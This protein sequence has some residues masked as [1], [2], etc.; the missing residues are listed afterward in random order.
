MLL[1][2][3][4]LLLESLIKWKGI[5]PGYRYILARQVILPPVFFTFVF[6]I[7]VVGFNGFLQINYLILMKMLVFRI[8]NNLK[9]ITLIGG[10]KYETIRL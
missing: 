9:S 7:G 2:I 4:V 10:I 5:I 8:I 3:Y 6:W 1:I